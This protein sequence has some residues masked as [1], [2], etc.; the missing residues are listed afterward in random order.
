MINLP[1]EFEDCVCIGNHN[2]HESCRDQYTLLEQGQVARIKPKSH[3]ETVKVIVIDGCVEKGNFSKCDSLFIYENEKGQVFSF[4]V[5]LKNSERWPKPV[6]QLEAVKGTRR[7][8]DLID[9]LAIS[10]RNELK[11]MKNRNI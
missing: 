5:E 11:R 4:L 1:Q 8:R 7:Y 2:P 9:S 6:E 10:K 3:H